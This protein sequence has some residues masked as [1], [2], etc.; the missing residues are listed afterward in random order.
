MPALSHYLF[1]RI[2][3]AG[4]YSLGF[5][6]AGFSFDFHTETCG[7]WILAGEHAVLRG[8]GALVFPIFSKRLILN[9]NASSEVL[10][11]DFHG[12]HHDLLHLLFWSV[13]E[14][15]LRLL[16]R[17]LHEVKG[18]FSLTNYIPVGAGMGASAALCVA[19]ARWFLF[20][21]WLEKDEAYHFAK[22]LEDLF[23]GKSSG[24][25][26]RG[27]SAEGGI[28]F[29]QGEAYPVDQVW[30]PV[31]CLSFCGQQAL[32]SSC[33]EKVE[34]LWQTDTQ[35]ARFI[36]EQMALSVEKAK[37]AL[38]IASE[39]S[40]LIESMNIAKNCFESWGLTHESMQAHMAMLKKK[41]ALAMKPTGSGNGGY[42]LSLWESEAKLNDS[43]G[44]DTSWIRISSIRG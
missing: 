22:S 41:G 31:F 1:S 43:V 42:I 19:V 28:Y 40:L 6:V 26:I 7:K 2:I 9:Y 38:S 11:A 3:R 15:G 16:N 21:G 37:Q 27:V 12:L 35:K 36:D 32:T 18:Y 23:H 8:E 4:Y 17:E 30:A 39:V 5:F 14:H 13:L 25:D 33:I 20:Q 10:R 44:N 24:L 34:K 29:R